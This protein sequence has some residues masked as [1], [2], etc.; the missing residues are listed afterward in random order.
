LLNLPKGVAESIDPNSS[1]KV[2]DYSVQPIVE[3]NTRQI[4]KLSR[5][6]LDLISEVLSSHKELLEFFGYSIVA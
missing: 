3:Q 6:E 4:A 2:K 5:N 1:V